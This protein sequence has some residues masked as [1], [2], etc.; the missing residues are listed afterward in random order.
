MQIIQYMCTVANTPVLFTSIMVQ[1]NDIFID[2]QLTLRQF[3]FCILPIYTVFVP[4]ARTLNNMIYTKN[5]NKIRQEHIVVSI[6]RLKNESKQADKV[7]VKLKFGNS[8]SF[9]LQLELQPTS[10]IHYEIGSMQEKI[11]KDIRIFFCIK[12][13]S[14]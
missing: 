12:T 5:K 1:K 4:F 9:P 6:F 14:S 10:A 3:C 2:L 13:K 11:K 7:L 8:K